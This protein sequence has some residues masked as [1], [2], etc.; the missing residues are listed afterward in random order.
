M[1]TPAYPL[2]FISA[3]KYSA[4][5]W[6]AYP[7]A[8][9]C[10]I[11]PSNPPLNIQLPSEFGGPSHR[12]GTWKV[13]AEVPSP[14]TPEDLFG[15]ALANCFVATFKVFAQNSK[16]DYADLSVRVIYTIDLNE[17]LPNITEANFDVHLRGVENRVRAERLLRKVSENCLI[18][19]AVQ[20]PKT[21]SFAVEEK[22]L[23]QTHVG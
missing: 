6:T 18:I 1:T 2:R 9:S 11:T 23:H 20:V 15:M 17:R 4:H 13:A 3:S 5:E 12:S 10:G 7:V 21:F 8:P 19:N 16:I 22:P 14:Y